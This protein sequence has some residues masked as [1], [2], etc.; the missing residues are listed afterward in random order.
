MN[1]LSVS[2]GGFAGGEKDL[3]V[4]W[5]V[6][7]LFQFVNRLSVSSG[8]LA[9]GREGFEGWLAACSNL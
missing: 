5:L 8:G 3:R 7:R 6:G 4:G 2:S 9:G 1:C